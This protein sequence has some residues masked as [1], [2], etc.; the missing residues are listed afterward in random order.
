MANSGTGQNLG[1]VLARAAG[2]GVSAIPGGMAQERQ[3][4][5]ENI[6]TVMGMQRQIQAEERAQEQ[7]D[8]SRARLQIAQDAE[9]RAADS[10]LT[11]TEE[12][13]AAL[14]QARKLGEIGTEQKL[15]LEGDILNL[16]RQQA[17]DILG[18]LVGTT[19][20][21]FIGPF[22]G[23]N[24]FQQVPLKLSEQVAL[25]QE[26]FPTLDLN[27]GG[28]LSIPGITPAKAGGE[29]AASQRA[30]VNFKE[31]MAKKQSIREFNEVYQQYPQHLKDKI[32]LSAVTTEGDMKKV[33]GSKLA[34]GVDVGK[35]MWILG[36]RGYFDQPKWIAIN[37]QLQQK[38]DEYVG[39]G[40]TTDPL[41]AKIE[42]LNRR[43][44][45][46]Q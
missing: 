36:R 18:G 15:K 11:P 9:G 46:L 2:K 20:D 17:R 23:E 6:M 13:E 34:R 37:K 22:V 19:R 1:S 29:T 35:D 4:T 14:G 25:A 26:Q 30:Q 21:E 5:L 27:L 24:A 10:Y 31:K 42:E 32:G 38:F 7:L 40:R 33:L 41:D 16:R 45:A 3:Q 12:R 44:E 28:G 8:I 43:L 39:M